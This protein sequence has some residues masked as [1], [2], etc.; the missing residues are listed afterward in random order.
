MHTGTYLTIED[1]SVF[2]A[3][4]GI[5]VVASEYPVAWAVRRDG[6]ETREGSTSSSHGMDVRCVN[7]VA[8]QQ[9]QGLLMIMMVVDCISCTLI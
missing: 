2:G 9:T 4:V 7:F 8:I 6:P 3:D 1:L 5:P